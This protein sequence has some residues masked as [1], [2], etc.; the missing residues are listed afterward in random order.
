VAVAVEV[1]GLQSSALI[2]AFPEHFGWDWIGVRCDPF[3]DFHCDSM[4]GLEFYLNVPTTEDATM[5]PAEVQ[6][7]VVSQNCSLVKVMILSAITIKY[8]QIHP[9]YIGSH[10]DF[11]H[12]CYIK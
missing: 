6:L 12:N 9:W 3:P 2:V 11:L 4:G 8:N 1:D 10:N 7:S 5:F